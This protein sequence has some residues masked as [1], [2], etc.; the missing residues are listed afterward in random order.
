MCLE[1]L[2][3]KSQKLLFSN[4]VFPPQFN[5]TFVTCHFDAKPK[6]Q[7]INLP[8][9]AQMFHRDYLTDN[10]FGTNRFRSWMHDKNTEHAISP[11]QKSNWR[12]V[13][14]NDFV[15]RLILANQ[16][17]EVSSQGIENVT[18]MQGSKMECLCFLRSYLYLFW[19]LIV[20]GVP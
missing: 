13:Q 6:N 15:E 10:I 5:E 8:T 3:Q 20:L 2:N 19:I 12:K 1:L 4:P 18:H 16:E 14:E 9:L 7:T 17:I 11:T